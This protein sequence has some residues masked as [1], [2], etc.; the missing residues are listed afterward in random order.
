VARLRLPRRHRLRSRGGMGVERP[1]DPGHPGAAPQSRPG[2]VRA[3]ADPPALCR[4]AGARR[5]RP[6]SAVVPP[7]RALGGGLRLRDG[8]LVHVVGRLVARKPDALRRRAHPRRRPGVRAPRG[9][10]ETVPPGSHR[11]GRRALGGDPGLAH[12]LRRL[13]LLRAGDE[14][15]QRG[16]SAALESGHPSAGGPRPV[17]RPGAVGDAPSVSSAV[18]GPAR[19]S[20]RGTPSRPRSARRS[21]GPARG[22]SPVR[23]PRIRRSRSGP[24]PSG[25]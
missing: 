18:G 16:A 21:S 19:S 20:T 8:P 4:G 10:A 6:E 1:A 7:A 5:P 24:S 12:L 15:R 22:R 14:P 23:T 25:R 2:T 3:G 9:V 17:A 13:A 11:R